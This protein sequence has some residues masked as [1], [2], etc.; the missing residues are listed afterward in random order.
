[1]PR[2]VTSVSITIILPVESGNRIVAGIQLRFYC[3]SH[4]TGVVFPIPLAAL[5]AVT[6]G[7]LPRLSYRFSLRTLLIATTLV[8][9][10]LGLA[11]ILH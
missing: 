5:L 7:A 4:S 10:V 9:V 3:I 1:M 2:K 11:I 6:L 8:A